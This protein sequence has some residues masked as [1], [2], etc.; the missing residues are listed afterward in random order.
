MK[1]TLLGSGGGRF[2]TL[3]QHRETGG[4]VLEIGGKMLLFDPGPGCVINAKKYNVNLS[5][6]DGILVSHA[7][8]D[9]TNDMN[10]AI[11]VM[12]GGAKKKR[13]F[14]IADQVTINGGKGEPARLTEYHRGPL[15][16]VDVMKPGETLEIH[17][18][19]I[20]ATKSTHE[21]RKPDLD[22]GNNKIP[23]HGYVVESNGEK[24]GY[25]SDGEYY[26]GM[27]KSFQNC[28]LL[29]INSMRPSDAPWPGQMDAGQ[30]RLLI[31]KT[32]PGIAVLSH[33][34]MKMIF[35]RA[36]KEA[37]NIQ[38][39]T[40]IKTIAARDGMVID[41]KRKDSSGISSYLS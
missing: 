6:L 15:E 28:S 37:R 22:F 24:F 14:L 3:N 7:H 27:E 33:L 11:E 38:K 41:T 21:E 35:G 29:V 1:L 13:G 26:P 8:L 31:E 23:T 18:L 5:K 19:M 20:T 4:F 12:T 2:V 32:R 16:R 30:A 17:D 39:E 9:H 36:E 25:T 34:G 40:G 10:L